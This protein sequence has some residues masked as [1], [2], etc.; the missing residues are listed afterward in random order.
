M[1]RNSTLLLLS[2]AVLFGACGDGNNK[3]KEGRQQKTYTKEE[4]IKKNR[5]RDQAENRRIKKY[6]ERS[7]IDY[8]ETGTGLRYH[9]YEHGDTSRPKAEEGQIAVIDFTVTILTGDTAYASEP[10]RPGEFLIG[11]DYVESGLH[12]GITYL[13]PGDKAKLILPPHL[14]HGL[15]GDMNKIPMNATIIYDVH[16]LDVK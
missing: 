16:L 7:G 8:K 2:I 4:L 1:K 12:E 10:G 9:I 13:R 14:A 11:K 6:V 15:V 3:K 5:I